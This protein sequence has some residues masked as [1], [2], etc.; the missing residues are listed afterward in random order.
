MTEK[1]EQCFDDSVD[2]EKII[3]EMTNLG[4]AWVAGLYLSGSGAGADYI[5]AG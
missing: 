4:L 2:K 5:E 1:A 3:M